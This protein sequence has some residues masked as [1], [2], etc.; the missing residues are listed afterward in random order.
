[1][2]FDL[3]TA[4]I[5]AALAGGGALLG[6][7]SAAKDAQRRADARNVVLRD[8]MVRT[9]QNAADNR[10]LFDGRLGDFTN[11]PTAL[12]TA[13]DTRANNNAAALTEGNADDIP[14]SGSAPS[15]VRGE[16]AKRML[17][18]FQG[19][20]ERARSS[21][22]LGGY[23]D[24]W[25]GHNIGVGDT[26]N[27]IGTNNNFARGQMSLVPAMQDLAETSVYKP[28]SIL[29]QIMTFAGNVL[30]GAAGRGGLFGSGAAPTLMPSP[31]GPNTFAPMF[32]R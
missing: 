22:R 19:A 20:T 15:V 14:L 10:T 25:L 8:A 4:A 30:G 16:I 11:H 9:D 31:N 12:A 32:P 26:S 7:G 28:P 5:G 3:T 21:G 24:A 18:A 27:R 13:Q 29:P 6:K 23:N 17:T 1:M 2:A